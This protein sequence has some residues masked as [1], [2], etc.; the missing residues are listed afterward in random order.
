MPPIIVDQP[1]PPDTGEDLR[2]PNGQLVVCPTLSRPLRVYHDQIIVWGTLTRNSFT[3]PL[4]SAVLFPIVLDTG[5]ND[6][7]LMQR[8]QVEAW[9][10]PAFLAGASLTGDSLAVGRERILGWDLALWLYHNVPGTRD[11]DPAA[12]P[13]W[14]DLPLGVPLTPPGSASTKEKPLLGLRAIRFNR[15]TLSIDGQRERVWLDA[16]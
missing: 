6:A 9:L 10:A 1:W 8:R 11:P 3:M 2:R 12:S 4:P 7:F 15:L 5:F 14:I 16:P 13:V